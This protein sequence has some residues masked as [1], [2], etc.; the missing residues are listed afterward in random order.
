MPLQRH[1]ECQQRDLSNGYRVVFVPSRSRVAVLNAAACALLD[2]L[3]TP[4]MPDLLSADERAVA[5]YCAAL[6]LV[7]SP[8]EFPS[9]SFPA[10]SFA[11]SDE[12]VAWLHVS[13]ACNLRCSYCYVQTS[14]ALMEST[15]GYAAVDAVLRSAL[16]Y[17]YA[18]VLL[19]YAGG[20]PLLNLALVAQVH[21]Y[22][23]EQAG[24]AGIGLD[25]VVL[26][27]GTLLDTAAVQVLVCSGLRLAVSLD[28]TAA[29]HDRQRPTAQGKG[30]WDAVW[31]GITRARAAGV[32]LLVSVTV[33]GAT[34]E[35]LPAL[36]ALLRVHDIPFTLNL[37]REH[38]QSQQETALA[39]DEQTLIDGMRAA[40][41]V[42][43][44]DMPSYRL[45][46]CLLDR[47]H[48]GETHG[49]ACGVG[50][51]YLVI[52]QSGQV[53]MCH[54]DMNHTVAMVWDDDPLAAVRSDTEG[55]QN[56]AV[57]QREGFRSCPWR[58]WCAGGCSFA[59]HQA[60]GRYDGVSPLCG[61][62]QALCPEVVRL[63]G[64]R[65]LAGK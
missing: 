10:A 29:F 6:G 37:Y 46:G 16:C 14:P 59:T 33:S 32:D 17:G 44:Q 31:K 41:R 60:T 40:Y 25:G 45:L 35:G 21:Q 18:R 39:L 11:S 4:H 48:L 27:N 3:E 57:M 51:H 38:A 28:G 7:G 19:K 63:E 49:Y 61:V 12:L 22:A 65:L 30:S 26:S 2:R 20:E 52:D 15:T 54:M 56:P 23:Q 53:A 5:Q 24:L 9:P 1:A 8:Q 50:E 47:V 55:V 34:I 42:L 62:Y 36:V 64:L 13:N 58:F 43:E